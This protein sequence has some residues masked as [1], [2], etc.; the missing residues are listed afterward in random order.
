[1]TF[2][3]VQELPYY[4]FEI[5]SEIMQTE[6]KKQHENEIKRQKNSK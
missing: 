5:L 2:Q 1:M 4:S 3:E 6:E